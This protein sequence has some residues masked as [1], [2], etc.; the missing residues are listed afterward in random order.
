[1][2][3]SFSPQFLAAVASAALANG[4]DLIADADL[5]FEAG[6]MPRAMALSILATEELSKAFLL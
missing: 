4:H 6:R 5:L 3:K 2:A 1:V